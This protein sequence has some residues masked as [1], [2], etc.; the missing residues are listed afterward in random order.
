MAYTPIALPVTRTIIA[1]APWGIPI[2]NAVNQLGTDVTALQ[3]TTTPTA[4]TALTLQNGWTN[5]GSG[6]QVG[7]YRKIGDMVYIRAA[8]KAP[9]TA[10]TIGNLPAGFRPAFQLE[11][12]CSYYSG[13]RLICGVTVNGAGDVVAPDVVPV[14]ALLSL[15]VIAFSITP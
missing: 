9:G 1:T 8:L 3:G 2:T 13:S 15:S 14:N 12:P 4:W 6:T 5:Y 11:F 10:T 7:Q